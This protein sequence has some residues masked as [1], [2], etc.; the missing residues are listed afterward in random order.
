MNT[1][2]YFSISNDINNNNNKLRENLSNEEGKVNKCLNEVNYFRSCKRKS[3]IYGSD[4]PVS[5]KCPVITGDLDVNCNS[6][7]NNLTRRKTLV[8]DY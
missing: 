5:E 4:K 3:V 6:L 7:W 1:P 8:K 2:V